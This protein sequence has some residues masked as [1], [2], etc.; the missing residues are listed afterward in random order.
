MARIQRITDAL[1]QINEAVFQELC[2]AFLLLS[3]SNIRAFGR[4]GSH[5]FKQKTV[6]GTPDSYMLLSTGKYIFIEHSTNISEGV[7]KL[8]KDVRKCLDEK[9]TKIATKDIAEIIFCIN[10]NL[11]ASQTDRIKKEL[12]GTSIGLTIHMLDSL[13]MDILYHHRNLAHQYLDIP[14]DSAQIVSSDI[15]IQEYNKASK[16]I[17]TPLDNDFIKREEE[18]LQVIEAMDNCD[19]V[20]L[21]G[22]AGIGKTRLAL[23]AMKSFQEANTSYTGYSLSYK[24]HP[25]IEDLQQYF[26]VDKDYLLFVDDANRIDVFGQV[27]GFYTGIRK[28]HLKIICTVRDYACDLVEDFFKGGIPFTRIDITKLTDE[29]IT[30]IISKEPFTILNTSFQRPIIATADGN[31]RIALMMARLAKE[32]GSIEALHNLKELFEAYF[33]T[34]VIDD[35]LFNDPDTLRALGLISF[36]YTLPY[37]ESN[38]MEEVLGVFG[39]DYTKFKDTID[40]LE[41][42]ELIELQH[43]F[44]RIPEQNLSSY[45]FY[46]T[47]ISD[48]L[49]SFEALLEHYS[50][51]HAGRFRDTVIPS[52]NMFGPADVMELLKPSLQK[53]FRKIIDDQRKAV[54]YLA[55]FYYYLQPQAMEFVYSLIQ[56]KEPD[57]MT[58]YRIDAQ[59]QEYAFQKDPV[60]VLLGEYLNSYSEIGEIIELAV[61]Y[62]KRYPNVLS[63]WNEIMLAKLPFDEPDKRSGYYRQHAVVDSLLKGA[64]ANDTLCARY[65]FSIAQKLLQFQFQQM[66]AG[67]HSSYEIYDF[68]LS[69]DHKLQE[70]RAKIWVGVDVLFVAHQQEA[71]TLLKAY[72]GGRSSEAKEIVESDI[73]YIV[74]IADNYLDQGNFEH[75]LTLQELIRRAKRMKAECEDFTRLSTTYTNSAYVFFEKID[76]NRLGGKPRYECR[77][78]REYEKAKEQEIRSHFIFESQEDIQSFYDTLVMVRPF[79][80]RSQGYRFQLNLIMDENLKRNPEI[81][82][83]F[84]QLL[85]HNGNAIDSYPDLYFSRVLNTDEDALRLYQL[86]WDNEFNNKAQWKLLFFE[87]LDPSLASREYSDALV[88]CVISGEN[89]NML[90]FDRLEKYL[91]FDQ[92]LFQKLLEL[93]YKKNKEQEQRIE[94]SPDIFDTY[95][96]HLENTDNAIWRSYCQQDWIEGNAFD[97]QDKGFLNLMTDNRNF[98]QFYMECYLDENPIHVD[99]DFRNL[100]FLWGI[101]GFAGFLTPVFDAVIARE[102]AFSIGDHLCNCFFRNL[103][104]DAKEM[105]EHFIL[106]YCRTNFKDARRMEVLVNISNHALRGFSDSLM[107]AYLDKN[108]DVQDFKRIRWHIDS[109]GG[110]FYDSLAAKWSSAFDTVTATYPGIRMIGVRNYISEEIQ[111]CLKEKSLEKLKTFSRR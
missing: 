1:A 79:A 75:C 106:E 19:F 29:Q 9:K 80:I 95:L 110:D 72:G 17:G 52:N 51:S 11:D 33:A 46:K 109:N 82:F 62:G 14:F 53:H 40:K 60:I 71:I 16:S 74:Q 12:E 38:T 87:M 15:F 101:K 88:D 107:L 22:S 66:K 45:F 77:D 42:L 102:P 26:D 18:L 70:L 103:S 64:E 44:V 58:H 3:N 85:V 108:Q 57:A 104:G 63:H 93:A 48:S 6:A 100:S 2:D 68:P 24:N 96:H 7:A 81:A 47:F 10:F 43:D 25:I 73:P 97:Y 4:T 27:T 61:E 65:F 13:A 35:K 90:R 56:K 89:L 20:I 36:F 8:V 49:L 111:R 39:M 54:K 94:L 30:A 55:T 50:E 34:F 41:K 31:P 105:A 76:W 92:K 32:K 5:N 98:L 28:G 99:S 91:P 23:E 69:N 78:Q 83:A 86:I 84:L 67:R 59:R 37:R 21:T